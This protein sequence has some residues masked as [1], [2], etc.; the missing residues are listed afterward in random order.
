[1]NALCKEILD[2]AAGWF[3]AFRD[4]DAGEAAD[5]EWDQWMSEDIRHQQAYETVELAWELSADLAERPA[6]Q[7]L[8]REVAA[9]AG[10][11]TAGQPVRRAPRRSW[12][13]AAAAC[14]VAVGIVVGVRF[15]LYHETSVD[16][17]TATGEQRKV[18]LPDGSTVVL[19]TATRVV[20]R[21][22]MVRRRVDLLAGEAAF[23]VSPDKRHPFDVHALGGTVTAVGTE[24]DVRIGAGIVAVAEL[25]GSVSIEPSASTAGR[26]A[27][28]LVAGQAVEY[29]GDGS[30]SAIG[31][32]DVTRIRGWEAQRIVISNLP[33]V[34]AL[35]EYNRYIRIPIVIGDPDLGS[36]RI[37][38]VFRLGEQKA[39][40]DAL[41]Q[42][43]HVVA[44]PSDTEIVL[45]HR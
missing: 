14:V 27:L 19:N 6:L 32:A 23:S 39:F 22:S 21:Y 9:A 41:E 30:L 20:A 33:L 5:R 15:A 28:T 26:S 2:R 45:H 18:T 25:E 43:L 31:S 35:E 24:F 3:A 10:A 7:A 36:R 44:T 13:W 40:L 29:R 12:Q 37:N 17:A 11:A 34:Q 38:G 8:N 16:Y 42:G 4:V 1:M